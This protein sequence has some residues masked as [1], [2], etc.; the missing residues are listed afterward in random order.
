MLWYFPEGRGGW[1]VEGE[2]LAVGISCNPIWNGGDG[3][4]EILAGVN[5]ETA[6]ETGGN[7]EAAS[8]QGRR[9]E[10]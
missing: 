6:D 10:C 4:R 3:S 1:V 7:K 8:K 2:G 9:G 5:R